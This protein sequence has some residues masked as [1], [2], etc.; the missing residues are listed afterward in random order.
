MSVSLNGIEFPTNPDEYSSFFIDGKSF[1]ESL[2]PNISKDSVQTMSDL[3]FGL[4]KIVY[5]IIASCIKIL[6]KTDL[7]QSNVDEVFQL[8][9]NF[10]DK[11]FNITNSNGIGAVV[12]SILVGVTILYYLANQRGQA[13]KL[14]LRTLLIMTVT[15]VWFG[16]NNE[17]NGKAWGTLL[18][19]YALNLETAILDGVTSSSVAGGENG[20]DLSTT[21]KD[22]AP[23]E[24]VLNIYFQKAVIEPYLLMNY[25]TM[26][27]KTITEA[28]IDP[29]EF[30]SGDKEDKRKAL[31]EAKGD[32]K[33]EDS[34]KESEQK[35][36]AIRQNMTFLRGMDKVI[37]SCG[38]LLG[39]LSI[40]LPILMIALFRFILAI[41]ALLMM[42]G[43]V[44]FLIHACFP[45][46]KGNAIQAGVGNLFAFLFAKSSLSFGIFA[47]FLVFNLIDKVITG[48]NFAMYMVSAIIKI[49]V[50]RTSWK[51]KGKI[52]E[53]LG[54]RKVYNQT[55]QTTEKVKNAPRKILN[56]GV[57]NALKLAQ[58]A[59]FLPPH[60]KAGVFA[61]NGLKS[62]M[63]QQGKGKKGEQKQEN[64]NAQPTLTSILGK[65]TGEF[66]RNLVNRKKQKDSKQEKDV[67]FIRKKR[68]VRDKAGKI[69]QG[70]G[71]TLFQRIKGG[72]YVPT[73]NQASI[74]VPVLFKNGKIRKK[75]IKP[76]EIKQRYQMTKDK[77]GRTVVTPLS[78]TQ[79]GVPYNFKFTTEQTAL[80]QKI[81]RTEIQMKMKH[82]RLSSP[83]MR[84]QQQNRRFQPVLEKKISP[85]L[86]GVK[87]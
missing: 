80:L 20:I 25:G 14:L 18:N 22:K 36:Y 66:T 69:H 68:G 33:F 7:F 12:L 3:F 63:N 6:Y 85:N 37:I 50:V 9:Q 58:N 51:N 17:N 55:K 87:Q 59:P 62:G 70:F 43:M 29:L 75:A 81:R 23:S 10:Y 82:K 65:K 28:G 34:K 44:F 56:N 49:V 30:L 27:V 1:L 84:S 32:L 57:D 15:T 73:K 60:I 4:N 74:K 38:S 72:K 86:R 2:M 26:N 16:K 47:L 61:L 31:D 24:A 5:S 67:L 76:F 71:A 21:I 40:G 45:F 83:E 42:L 54:L 8:S 52:L 79:K 64:R 48:S 53:K 11:I 39:N 46:S 35:I 41:G 78:A 13:K 77:T 19:D